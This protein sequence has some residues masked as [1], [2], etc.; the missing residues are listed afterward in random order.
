MSRLLLVGLVS[1]LSLLSESCRSDGHSAPDEMGAPPAARN[2]EI[3]ERWRLLGMPS[4]D[5]VTVRTDTNQDRFVA[6]YRDCSLE[7]LARR[8]GGSLTAAGFRQTCSQFEGQVL[9][10]SKGSEN[11]LVKVDALGSTIALSVANQSGA[12]KL[13]YGACF[14]GYEVRPAASR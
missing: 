7:E 8:V 4:Q 9:G 13:L 10:Y 12:D 11:L 2:L 1:T 6:D 14:S 3:P 5:L